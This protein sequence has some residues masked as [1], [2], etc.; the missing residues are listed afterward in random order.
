M[1][2]CAKDM[3]P[4]ELFVVESCGEV[5][6][7]VGPHMHSP[8]FHFVMLRR[9]Q[10]MPDGLQHVMKVF[11]LHAVCHVLPAE[12]AKQSFQAIADAMDDWI[13]VS[14]TSGAR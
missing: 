1:I 8:G 13:A 7:Y 2:K 10:Y 3:R 9:D 4:G 12:S 5:F 6:E 11:S 14:Q